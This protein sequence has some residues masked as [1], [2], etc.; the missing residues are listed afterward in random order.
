M[1]KNMR[2]FIICTVFALII[3]CKNYVNGQSSETSEQSLEIPQQIEQEIKKEFNG[4][5]NIL[6]T[7]DLNT[8]DGKDTKEIEKI[9][10]DLKEKIEKTD[11]KKTPLKTYSGY[12]EQIKKIREKLKGKNLEDKLKELEE[13]LKNKKEERKKAL[14]EAKQ[15]F[16][17][18]KGQVG[19]A[20]GVTDGDQSRNQGKVGGQAWTKA[21]EYGL[22]VNST[23]SGTDTGVMSSGII[24]DALKQIEEELKNIGEEAQNSEKKK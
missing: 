10:Q 22:S 24:D 1:N 12:E 16:E 17:K 15:E 19:S 5:L 13:S 6:E 2:M 18:F 14:Q 20:T 21:R 11:S 3:S 23:S 7:K 4:L 9:I 8:L